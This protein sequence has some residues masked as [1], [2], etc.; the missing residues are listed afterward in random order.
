MSIVPGSIST[1]L[2]SANSELTV[3]APLVLVR[4]TYI[5]QGMPVKAGQ[6]CQWQSWNCDILESSCGSLKA[7]IS[8][9]SKGARKVNYVALI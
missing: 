8:N 4:R 6:D 9:N 2:F 7:E 1:I 3:D 5:I